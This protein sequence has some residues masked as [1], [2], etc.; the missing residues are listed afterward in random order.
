MNWC[1]W[2]ENDVFSPLTVIFNRILTSSGLNTINS[3]H[4]NDLKQYLTLK[5]RSYI[6]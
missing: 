4:S 6:L 3:A 5:T 2:A 1:E